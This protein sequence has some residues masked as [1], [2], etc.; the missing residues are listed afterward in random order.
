MAKRRA[1]IPSTLHIGA[2]LPVQPLRH[3]RAT[4]TSLTAH[5]EDDDAPWDEGRRLVHLG[6]DDTSDALARYPRKPKATFQRPSH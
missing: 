2:V 4:R 6:S 3:G 5:R 1:I